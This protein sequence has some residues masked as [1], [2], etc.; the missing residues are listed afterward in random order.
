V[1]L[2]EFGVAR[3][4]ASGLQP[5]S[6]YNGATNALHF[7]GLRSGPSIQPMSQAPD[8]R[9]L[10]NKGSRSKTPTDGL[11]GQI[12]ELL[13]SLKAPIAQYNPPSKVAFVASHLSIPTSP[14]VQLDCCCTDTDTYQGN[15]L[16][17]ARV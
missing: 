4:L 5:A 6:L 7:A 15:S 8:R 14:D 16:H 13:S 1:D 11:C 2:S 3:R 9:R 10:L 17:E 12:P